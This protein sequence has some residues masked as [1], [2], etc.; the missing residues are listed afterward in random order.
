MK[1]ACISWPSDIDGLV[2]SLLQDAFSSEYVCVWR[3]AS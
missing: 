1:D 3:G 2:A